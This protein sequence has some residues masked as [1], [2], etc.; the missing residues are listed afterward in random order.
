[1]ETDRRTLTA[2]FKSAAFAQMPQKT[3]GKIY[4]SGEKFK[5]DVGG[6][7]RVKFKR[8]FLATAGEIGPLTVSDSLGNCQDLEALLVRYPLESSDGTL[9]YIADRAA[10]NRRLGDEMD[11]IRAGKNIGPIP[12]ILPLRDYQMIPV[13]MVRRQG[14]VL[15]GDSLGLGKTAC[16]VG[17]HAAGLGPTVVICQT[18]LTAQWASQIRKF[19][20]NG[21]RI[22]IQS[23]GKGTIPT[24]DVLIMTFNMVSKWQHM[25]D[26][27]NMLVIDEAQELRHRGTQK[28]AACYELA[29]KCNSIMLLTATPVINYGDEIFSLLDLMNP[30]CLGSFDEFCREWCKPGKGGKYIVRDPVALGHYI[31]DQNLFV[32]RTRKDVGKELPPVNRVVVDIPFSEKVVEMMNRQSLQLAKAIL[33]SGSSFNERGLA[34]RELDMKL[35]Q[36]TGIAKAPQ[37]AL[38]VADLVESGEKVLVSGWHREV[39]NTMAEIFKSRDI[40][41]WLYTGSEK[42]SDKTKSAEE[43]MKS[44]KPGVMMMS[45]RSGAGLDGLQEHC[46]VVFHVELDWS[47]KI[48]DQLTGRLVRDGQDN[49]V[50]EVFAIANGGSDPVISGILGIKEEQATGIVDPNSVQIQPGEEEAVSAAEVSRGAALARRILESLGQDMPDRSKEEESDDDMDYAAIAAVLKEEAAAAAEKAPDG[51]LF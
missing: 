29:R 40:P 20:G 26:G 7:V 10:G 44:K 2:A 4:R 43:F 42:A 9:E 23:K 27:F 17:C 38:A 6:Q 16:G 14:F 3:Y 24:C 28:Y 36:Q 32:R 34:S 39:Y 22:H 50:T 41:Y 46:S 49:Q 48:M 45:L 51:W 37:C 21:I 35:R 47:R 31:A 15:C 19:L 30:G 12:M 18:H 33:S 13:E 5:I 8:W 25:L 11:L 1:M